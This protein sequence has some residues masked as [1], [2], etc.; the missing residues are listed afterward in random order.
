VVVLVVSSPSL[1]IMGDGSLLDEMKQF[2]SLHILC[3]VLESITHVGVADDVRAARVALFGSQKRSQSAAVILCL[4]RDTVASVRNA[5]VSGFESRVLFCL[6]T[7]FR[8]S[9]PCWHIWQSG[10]L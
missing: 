10:C 7:L 9:K 8:A 3:D 6:L 1:I 4:A 2:L 5:F